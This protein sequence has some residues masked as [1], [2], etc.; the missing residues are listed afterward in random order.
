VGGPPV[1]TLRQLT[2]DGAAELAHL[3]VPPALTA[4]ADPR[5]LMPPHVAA[6]SLRQISEGQSA[7]WC[8][9]F[10]IVRQADQY[11]VGACGFKHEP[12]Q[13]RVEIGYGVAP[14]CQR[15]GAATAA[16][17]QLLALAHAG[18]VAEVLAE[19]SPENAASTAVVRK[20]GFARRGTRVDDDGETVVQWLAIP[21]A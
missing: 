5:A 13:G 17:R 2:L 11:I 9:G 10:L 19:V 21:G 8:L 14:V 18:G 12:A 7:T 6:R 4:Q 16:V 20:L 1:Y 15:Q 3:Q